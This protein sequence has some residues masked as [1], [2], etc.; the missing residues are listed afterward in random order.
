MSLS[1]RGGWLIC[2]R[3]I[4]EVLRAALHVSGSVQ[5]VA[6]RTDLPPPLVTTAR[7][8]GSSTS[9]GNSHRIQAAAAA[10]NDRQQF[11]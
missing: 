10:T 4:E 5:L 8:N 3:S 2:M 6:R 9:T 1:F 11:T 7:H